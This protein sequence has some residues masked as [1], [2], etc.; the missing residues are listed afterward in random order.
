M[1]RRRRRIEGCIPHIRRIAAAVHELVALA[2]YI[3]QTLLLDSP[4][5]R[6]S[7]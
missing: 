3:F 7:R 4:E 2:I 6:T 5:D 1:F